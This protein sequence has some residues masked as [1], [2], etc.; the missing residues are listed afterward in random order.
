VTLLQILVVLAVVAAVA[1]VAAEVWRHGDTGPGDGAE[2]TEAHGES[3][4]GLPEPTSSVPLLRLPADRLTGQD[5]D[6]LRFSVGLRG[7][8]MDEVDHVLD[9]VSAELRSRQAELDELRERLDTRPA[10]VGGE[11][12]PAPVAPEQTQD[13]GER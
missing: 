2:S 13:A 12:A 4:V 8:R 11:Q 7:Y 5:V 6:R 10:D 9:R 3:E 1:A